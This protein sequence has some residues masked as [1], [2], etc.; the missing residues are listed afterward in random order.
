MAT[1]QFT[2]PEQGV[3]CKIITWPDLKQGD[4]GQAFDYIEYADTTVQVISAA[5]GGATL[6]WQ[7]SNDK[8]NW[9]T[10]TDAFGSATSFAAP[11]IKIV[12]ERPAYLRPS[13]SGGDGTTDITVI[14]A[15]RRGVR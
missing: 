14:V 13:V 5:M 4:V 6:V 2:A 9:A 12:M 3:L 11:G 7:G 8:T 10:L 1:V 15:A